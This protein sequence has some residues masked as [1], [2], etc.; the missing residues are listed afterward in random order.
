MLRMEEELHNL[1]LHNCKSPP[2]Q[3][4]QVYDVNHKPEDD[5]SSPDSP[6]G[7][8]VQIGYKDS[9]RSTNWMEGIMGCLRPVWTIIGKAAISEKAVSSKYLGVP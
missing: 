6:N 2:L 9:Q 8:P 1:Q 4:T 3:Q 7:V 5:C